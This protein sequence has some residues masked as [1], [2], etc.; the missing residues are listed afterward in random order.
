MNKNGLI[1]VISYH[2]RN[3]L[4]PPLR[5]ERP[6]VHYIHT[7]QYKT[8]ITYVQKTENIRIFVCQ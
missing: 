5:N 2:I 3:L 4:V 1:H 8:L 7:K 6:W